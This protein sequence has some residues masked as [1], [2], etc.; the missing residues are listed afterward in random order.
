MQI[1]ERH[2]MP[3][4]GSSCRGPREA[5]PRACTSRFSG[6]RISLN[7]KAMPGGRTPAY[8]SQVASGNHSAAGVLAPRTVSYA[9]PRGFDPRPRYHQPSTMDM[10]WTTAA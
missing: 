9:V 7:A 3:H 5:G 8:T 6:I 10:Q 4:R 1:I 2:D